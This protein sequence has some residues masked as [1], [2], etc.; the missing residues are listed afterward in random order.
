MLLLYAYVVKYMAGI[1]AN[2]HVYIKLFL[3]HSIF[4]AEV[5]KLSSYTGGYYT[6]SYG[7][8]RFGLQS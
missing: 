8:F 5:S 4:E 2:A 3:M 7:I 6:F 1:T